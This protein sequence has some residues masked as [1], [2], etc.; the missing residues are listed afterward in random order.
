MRAHLRVTQGLVDNARSDLMRPHAF[1]HERVA[2]ITCKFGALANGDIAILADGYHPVADE[3]YIRDLR[4]GALIGSGAFRSALQ[5][6]FTH[7]VGLFHTHLHPHHGIPRPSRIDLRETAKFVPD[8]FNV[9]PALPHG[10]LILSLDALSG[11]VWMTARTS[12]R[13]IAQVTIVGAPIMTFRA[14]A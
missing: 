4:Y 13:P 1:A 7:N 3:D 2:F 14:G 5:L 9:R 10:A 11:R 6:A 12:P 8:F